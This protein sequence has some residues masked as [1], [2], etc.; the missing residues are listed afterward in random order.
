MAFSSFNI[1]TDIKVQAEQLTEDRSIITPRGTEQGKEGDWE[2]TFP[3][4]NV[5]RFTDEEWQEAQGKSDKEKQ[6]ELSGE[7]ISSPG[8]VESDE[9][10]NAEEGTTG[11]E[12][13]AEEKSETPKK[14]PQHSSHDDDERF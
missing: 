11:D 13:D 7:G 1:R 3:D 14:T 12:K 10:E 6:T 8:N 5:Q 9:K 2:V 4:G